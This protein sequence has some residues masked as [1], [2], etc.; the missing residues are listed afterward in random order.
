ML[1]LWCIFISI[2]SLYFFGLPLARFLYG[3]DEEKETIWII[4]PFIGLSTITLISQNLVYLN[5]PI[6]VSGFWV[7]VGG[8]LFWIYIILRRKNFLTPPGFPCSL[9]LTALAAYLIQGLG[10]LVAGAEAYVGRAWHDQFN[11]TAMAQ[12]FTDYPFRLT[13]QDVQNQPYLYSGIFYKSDRIGSSIWQGWLSVSSLT[14]AKTAFEPAILLSPFLIVLAVYQL[15]HKLTLPKPWT[16]AAAFCAGLMPGIAMV[17]LE[18]FFAQALGI[19]FLLLWPFVLHRCLNRPTWKNLLLASL[20]WAAA[21]TFYTEFYILF[22]GLGLLLFGFH[23][24]FSTEKK[25]PFVF[26]FILLFLSAFL[27]NIGF[28]KG[29]WA[30]LKRVKPEDVLGTIYPWANSLE[31][32]QRLWLGDF[33]GRLEPMLNWI[34]IAFSCFLILMAIWGLGKTFWKQKNALVLGVLAMALFPLG[35]GLVGSRFAY[36]FYKILLSVSPLLPLG[37]AMAVTENIEASRSHKIFW[38]RLGKLTLFLLLSFSLTATAHMAWRAGHG[39]TEKE[40]GRGGA[41]KL[42]DPATIKLQKLL[43]NT[44]DQ[45]IL[46]L[47]KDDFYNGDYLRGWL[48]YFARKNKVWFDNPR[49]GN[50]NLKDLAGAKW[51]PDRLPQNGYLLTSSMFAPSVAAPSV[52]LVWSEGPYS[53]WKIGDQNWGAFLKDIDNPNGLE[54][55]DGDDAFWVGN[56]DSVLETLSGRA[57]ILILEARFSPGPSLP[58]T[59]KRSFQISTDSGYLEKKQINTP[60]VYQFS[61]PIVAGQ[62]RIKIRALDQPIITRLPSGDTRPLLFQIRDL[63]IVDFKRENRLLSTGGSYSLL[64]VD[65]GKSEPAFECKFLGFSSHDFVNLSENAG[66]DGQFDALF[67]LDIKTSGKIT[68]IEIRNT[69]GVHSVWDTIPGNGAVL[70]GVADSEKPDSLLNKPDGSIAIDVHQAQ[71]LFLYAADNSSLKDGK[72]RYQVTVRL[73]NGHLATVPIKRD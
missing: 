36:Q 18:S 48:A 23:L 70:L 11:Y 17:H 69:D 34:S 2:V 46:I 47:W 66:P 10:L 41:H 72:T 4:A 31:G 60:G 22:L 3:Q 45:N 55:V 43:S 8:S 21:A 44:E 12:F 25:I 58:T 67:M 64:Q 68:S 42:A 49:I 24:L 19:P 16:V 20:L 5:I 28:I 14:S 40:I 62:T 61:V 50:L 6:K 26:F 13:F 35:V 53:L 32:L 39:K 57:G 37:I 73:S 65:P 52:R 54:K 33:V 15:G 51:L 63:K 56:G 7:W 1:T 29:I 27:L 38:N 59:E 30:I 71:R 9:F